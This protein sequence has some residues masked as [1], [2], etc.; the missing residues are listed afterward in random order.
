[1]VILPVMIGWALLC[2][3]IVQPLTVNILVTTAEGEK[4]GVVKHK[5][6]LKAFAWK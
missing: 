3:I 1:M 5:I 2:S 6:T 4:K